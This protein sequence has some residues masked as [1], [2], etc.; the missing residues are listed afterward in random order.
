MRPIVIVSAAMLADLLTF[1]LVVPLVTIEAEMNPIMH[2]GYEAFGL[3]FVAA[4]KPLI[5]RNQL[6][7][8]TPTW[9]RLVDNRRGFGYKQ[10]WTLP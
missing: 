1:A 6:Y 3:P 10:E 7:V 4:L 5:A 2:Q 8:F 9:L